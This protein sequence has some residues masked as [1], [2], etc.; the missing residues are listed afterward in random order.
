[1]TR[2]PERMAKPDLDPR[3]GQIDATTE[4]RRSSAK[5]WQS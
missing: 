2:Q 3:R 1:M 5:R 4:T